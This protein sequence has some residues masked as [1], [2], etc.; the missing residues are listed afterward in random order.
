MWHRLRNAD[1]AMIRRPRTRMTVAQLKRHMD[2]R[3][4]HLDR[5]MVDK[6]DLAGFA[7]KDDLKRFATKDDL[8]RYATKDD[9]RNELKRFATKA[10]MDR[11]FA[12]LNAK[13]DSM[14]SMIR[15]NCDV[16]D[17]VAEEHD[18]RISD[19]EMRANGQQRLFPEG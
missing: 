2:R 11:G 18:R 13:L 8:K 17:R 19:L 6:S 1:D 14:M 12:S 5:T 15:I 4:D 7:T 3:F 9:L 10:E 16:L